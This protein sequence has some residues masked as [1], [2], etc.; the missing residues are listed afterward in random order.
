VG[1]IP[2]DS[3]KNYYAYSTKHNY[4][5]ALNVSNNYKSDFI[6]ENVACIRDKDEKMLYAFYPEAVVGIDEEDEVSFLSKFELLQNYPNP[7]NPITNI[8]YYI[9][10]SSNVE[11]TI[12]NILG[13]KVASLVS[14]KQQMGKYIVKWNA[15]KHSSGMYFYKLTAQQTDGKKNMVTNFTQIKKLVVIK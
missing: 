1:L 11:L 15:S 4:W 7:F 14:E 6:G 10:R 8:E 5:A 3:R 12:Y 2:V 13:Q 9:P